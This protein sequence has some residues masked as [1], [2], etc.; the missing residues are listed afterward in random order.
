MWRPW[1]DGVS[2]TVVDPLC[3]QQGNDL[4]FDSTKNPIE[5]KP[6]FYELLV[7]DWKV[8]ENSN[9]FF[10]DQ[11]KNPMFLKKC[12]YISFRYNCSRHD[13]SPNS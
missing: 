2:H 3:E 9:Y 4:F 12:K 8:L 11:T 1:P 7:R 10:P 6:A 5:S 13:I